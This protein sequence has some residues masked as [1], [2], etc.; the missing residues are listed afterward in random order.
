MQPNPIPYLSPNWNEV[1]FD[2]I[3]DSERIT[4]GDPFW[5]DP[6]IKSLLPPADKVF[7]VSPFSAQQAGL[8]EK[9]KIPCA[10]RPGI[11]LRSVAYLYFL[12]PI[13]FL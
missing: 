12:F 13:R 4:S 6:S 7:F 8:G 2:Y 11:L 1:S 5:G 10:S 3:L 9:Q